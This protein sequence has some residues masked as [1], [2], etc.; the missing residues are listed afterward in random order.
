MHGLLTA[1][2]H[3]HIP[4]G[5]DRTLQSLGA[6]VLSPTP[7]KMGNSTTWKVDQTI[8]GWLKDNSDWNF[9]GFY[10]TTMEK[11]G[12]TSNCDICSS[13]TICKHNYVHVLMY[14]SGQSKQCSL[15]WRKLLEASL[16]LTIYTWIFL[17]YK[18]HQISVQG[19]FWFD[20]CPFSLDL[21][22]SK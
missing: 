5:S 17:G 19:R 22:I 3:P 18:F 7:K 13:Q 9:G 21:S 1:S 4:T 10:W 14:V 8:P 2:T 12:Y 6:R 16:N 11:G 15:K 20:F